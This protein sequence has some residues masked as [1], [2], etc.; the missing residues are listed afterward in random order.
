MPQPTHICPK[1]R[2]PQVAETFINDKGEL[3]KWCSWCRAAYR[4]RLT[5]LHQ[6]QK[7]AE[8]PFNLGDTEAIAKAEG[9]NDHP[10]AQL[11]ALSHIAGAKRALAIRDGK[12][13]RGKK[14]WRAYYEAKRALEAQVAGMIF[15]SSCNHYQP[16]SHF[17]ER[18]PKSGDV[19]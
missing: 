10:L 17:P 11:L 7:T 16:S 18:D 2:E 12:S 1:C 6:R 13:W 3:T 15:C 9:Y 19:S 14:A 8:K 4:G 5:S